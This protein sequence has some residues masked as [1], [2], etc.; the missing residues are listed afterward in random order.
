M[1]K[2]TWGFVSDLLRLLMG[3]KSL[4]EF[5]FGNL[6]RIFSFGAGVAYGTAVLA[7]LRDLGAIHI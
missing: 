5:G 2:W 3:I 1:L 6:Y 4:A 7:R